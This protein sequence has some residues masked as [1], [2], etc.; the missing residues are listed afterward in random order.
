LS[1][2]HLWKGSRRWALGQRRHI[3]LAPTSSP[4]V[5][6]KWCLRGWLDEAVVLALSPTPA[7]TVFLS[8]LTKYVYGWGWLA[9]L[10]LGSVQ[11]PNHQPPTQ[12]TFQENSQYEG[13]EVVG[14]ILCPNVVPLPQRLAKN[15][16]KQMVP[17]RR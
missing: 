4:D 6:P 8:E 11:I 1:R 12:A 14:M 13:E 16:S 10:D 15:I 5:V 9:A 17:V 3:L 7:W 2:A